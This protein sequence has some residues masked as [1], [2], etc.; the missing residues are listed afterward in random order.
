MPGSA[1]KRSW[2]LR[3]GS[4]R[5]IPG[6]VLGKDVLGADLLRV[7]D[8]CIQVGMQGVRTA[9]TEIGATFPTLEGAPIDTI[10]GSGN[11][12]SILYDGRYMFAKNWKLAVTGFDTGKATSSKLQ[13]FV[14]GRS[15]MEAEGEVHL[16][17]HVNAIQ[18]AGMPSAWRSL[19]SQKNWMLR[20]NRQW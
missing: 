18:Q 4:H 9:V 6:P 1:R 15:R 12:T 5:E 2:S 20:R 10:L 19:P 3:V 8:L 7:L 16:M 13:A 14:Q 17:G 11:E